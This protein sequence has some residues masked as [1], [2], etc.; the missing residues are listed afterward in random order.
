MPELLLKI[1]EMK[2]GK[3]KM[4]MGVFGLGNLGGKWM[5]IL[6][7]SII[8]VWKTIITLSIRI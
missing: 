6:M 4:L 3:E 5:L 1:V 8:D 7:T 2:I